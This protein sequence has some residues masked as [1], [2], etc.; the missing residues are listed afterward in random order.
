[1][2]KVQHWVGNFVLEK[3]GIER[4]FSSDFTTISIECILSDEYKAISGIQSFTVWQYISRKS[5]LKVGSE[6]LQKSVESRV[7]LLLEAG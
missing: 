7:S 3:S 5:Y 2:I 1:M 4:R 6:S